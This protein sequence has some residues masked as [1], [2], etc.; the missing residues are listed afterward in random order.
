MWSFLLGVTHAADSQKGQHHCPSWKSHKTS[1]NWSVNV[2][3]WESHPEGLKESH[4]ETLSKNTVGLQHCTDC[5]RTPRTAVYC[6]HWVTS[7]FTRHLKGVAVNYHTSSI[8]DRAD[9]TR[10]VRLHSFSLWERAE[11]HQLQPQT[12]IFC[13]V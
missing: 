6:Q 1:L 2:V 3:T 10:R 9:Q 11:D 7:M 13:R 4:K 5:S 12:E 8:Q